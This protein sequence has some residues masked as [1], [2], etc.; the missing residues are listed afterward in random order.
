MARMPVKW[1]RGDG[2]SRLDR[3]WIGIGNLFLL[4]DYFFV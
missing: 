1:A 3:V 4:E 2:Q